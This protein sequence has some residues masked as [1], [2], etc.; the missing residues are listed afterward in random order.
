MRKISGLEGA[1]LVL[2]AL[3]A[4]F[5]AGWLVRGAAEPPPVLVERSA[6][7]A[8]TAQPIPSAAGTPERAP[9]PSATPVQDKI[10]INT[11]DLEAL[12]TLPGIG[13]ARAQAILDDREA[14]G[15]FPIPEDITRVNGIG[16]GILENIIDYITVE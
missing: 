4:A 13:E 8:A 1:A 16:E 5:S 10:N 9:T 12:Q 3:C 7:T 15:P 6:F 11:A 2:T 14:N